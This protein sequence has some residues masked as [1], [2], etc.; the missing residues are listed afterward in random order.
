MYLNF[1]SL[2]IVFYYSLKIN[3]LNSSLLSMGIM[4]TFSFLMTRYTE[5]LYQAAVQYQ[6]TYLHEFRFLWFVGFAFWDAV[7]ITLVL[8]THH[9]FN[10]KRSFCSNVIIVAYAIKFH[11]HWSLYIEKEFFDS[12]YLEPFYRIGIPMINAVL[13]SS[14]FGFLLLVWVAMWLEMHTKFK[15]V[16]WRI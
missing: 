2:G 8:Y 7:I 6:H 10:L 15:G 1:L 3:K 11:L 16:S 14:L 12:K 13:A 4:M 9:H 5:P